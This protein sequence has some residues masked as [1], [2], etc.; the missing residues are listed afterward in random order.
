MR[1]VT[2]QER[3]HPFVVCDGLAGGCGYCITLYLRETGQDVA[4]PPPLCMA[5]DG[6]HWPWR[7]HAGVPPA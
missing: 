6:R 7:P 3:E 4:G 5:C 2:D 1:A